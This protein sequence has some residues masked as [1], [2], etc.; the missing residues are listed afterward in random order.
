MRR[1]AALKSQTA[2]FNIVMQFVGFLWGSKNQRDKR[3]VDFKRKMLFPIR[4]TA[5]RRSNQRK[6]VVFRQDF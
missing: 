1:P 6:K 5:Y 2:T 3:K 4:V